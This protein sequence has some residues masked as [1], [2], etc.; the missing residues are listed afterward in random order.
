MF[1]SSAII[2]VHLENLR[3]NLKTL[4]ARHPSLMPVIKA[5]AYGH[6]VVAVARVLAEEGIQ[7]MAVGSVGEGAL[8][9]QEGH[10]AFLLALMGLARDEDTA[11]A[12]SYDITP[13]V[14]SRESLERILAQSH[15]AGRAKPLTV[16]IKFDTGM[17]RLGFRVDEAAELADYLRTLKEVRP[18]LVMSHLAASDTPALDDFTH[19]QARRFHEATESMK[20]VFPGLKTSLTN[21]PGLLCWPSYVGDLARPGVTLY[22][23]NPLHGTDRAKL[24]MGLLPVMEMAAPVLSVHPVVKGAT[25][26]YGCLYTAPK[27]I[28]AAVV[29]AGYADGYPRSLSMRGSV[30]IRG[31]RAPILGR[32]CMQMCIVDVTDIPGV[33]PGDTAYLLGGSGPLAIRPEELAE[34]WGTISYEV[35]CALGRN[36]RVSEKKFS[37]YSNRRA[38]ASASGA[39]GLPAAPFSAGSSSRLPHLPGSARSA[40]AGCHAPGKRPRSLKD[41]TGTCGVRARCTGKRLP[42]SLPQSAG[43]MP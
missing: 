15:L 26:S 27:D 35:F 37:E 20:A 40:R 1:L 39:A 6:G 25:V 32:V 22:G 41:S 4:L 3:H 42:H 11:L 9:R 33:E 38:L 28:R 16:A 23:G 30:L 34:W 43:T 36:R 13:L 29:G 31:Q 10:T 21:S 17:S 24:G 18:V 8:L 7:H 19:E 5:D 2:T 12:A 14:H